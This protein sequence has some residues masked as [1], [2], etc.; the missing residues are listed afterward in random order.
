MCA[1]R[2][3]F[4]RESQVIDA[5]VRASAPGQFVDLPDGMVHY[6]MAG[7]PRAETV[8]LIPG[9]SVPYFA[10]D[11]TFKA[12]VDAQ[13]RVL[14]YDLYGR[15]FSDRPDTVYDR[16][17]F[18]RQ[19]WNL[20]S[21]LD[22][23]GPVDLVGWS[24]GGPI[25]VV[26]ASRHPE[27]VRKLCL[28]D[29]AGLPWQQPLSARLVEVPVLGELFMNLLGDRVLVSNL[30]GYFHGD[31]PPAEFVQKFRAQMQYAGFKKALLS[32]LRSGVTTGATEAYRQIGERGCPVLLIW[33]R[34][35]R[36]VPFELSERV[37]EL[38]PDAE[39]HAIENA[40]HNPHY[41]R[42]EAVNP[43]LIEFLNA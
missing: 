35:D 41:E 30:Q 20:L 11:P 19:L 29:P 4:R 34:E 27:S 5:E 31:G 22:I 7:S 33:G 14:R 18:D 40:A 1:Q 15:G 23:T 12:L 16:G 24:M 43:L 8:V 17:L 9:L 2:L 32:T 26:F 42:P 3:A 6:E 37:K 39:F 10:W 38:I 36:V 28:I 25:S 13:L 21:A